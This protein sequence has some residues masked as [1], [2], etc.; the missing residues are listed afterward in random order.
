MS[1]LRATRKHILKLMNNPDNVCRTRKWALRRCASICA[2][3][4]HAWSVP[5]ELFIIY[6]YNAMQWL[7]RPW[8]NIYLHGD[9]IHAILFNFSCIFFRFI[10]KTIGGWIL[11]TSTL[12]LLLL[13]LIKASISKSLK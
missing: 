6:L 3:L 10:F 5:I 12:I 9:D 13:E 2:P 8:K 11:L 4:V 1:F 7:N